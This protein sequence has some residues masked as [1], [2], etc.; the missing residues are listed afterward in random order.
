MDNY[1]IN[2]I[3]TDEFG[4]KS[5]ILLIDKPIE[6]TSHDVVTRFRKELDTR[7]IGHAGALDPFAS[8]ILI[9]LVGKATKLS[10]SFLTL[11]KEY[12]AEVLLGIGTDGGD[13]EG[14]IINH[15]NHQEPN[16]A[17]SSELIAHSPKQKID[18]RNSQ[19]TTQE[20]AHVLK[21]FQPS[22]EQYVPVFSSVKV[23]G[24]KLRKLARSYA[25]FEI[26]DKDNNKF[27]EFKNDKNEIEK[28][29]TLPK[30]NVNIYELELIEV[31]KLEG[32]KVRKLYEDK[33]F[34]LKDSDE[35]QVLKIRV[36]CSKGTYIRQLAIDIGEKLGV[37]AS[38]ISLRRTE[39][40]EYGIE[41]TISIED[42]VA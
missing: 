41:N 11:D 2:K 18:T 28:E 42:E 37:P 15:L 14:K 5:G 24:Q 13:R 36:K 30:K 21:T 17:T 38:L 39:I 22:Y 26:I 23:D 4:R 9:I 20:I 16:E 6:M 29:I 40:G 19:L 10:D 7:K 32:S 34:E 12:E 25:G 31:G 8:G 1:E 33:S 3:Q 35:F 27:I